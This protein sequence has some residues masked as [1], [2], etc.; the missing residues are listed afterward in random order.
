[1][2]LYLSIF[3]E[4]SKVSSLGSS[5]IFK[6]V[7]ESPETRMLGGTSVLV[8]MLCAQNNNNTKKSRSACIMH[9]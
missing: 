2:C 4:F 5:I 9:F 6:S 8:E 3:L 7:K 1:M